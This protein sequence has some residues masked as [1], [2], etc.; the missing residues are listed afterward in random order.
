R[1]PN[2]S[3]VICVPLAAGYT[4]CRG[5]TEILD[6]SADRLDE[7]LYPILV[8]R[9]SCG[10]ILL[11]N[12]TDHSLPQAKLPEIIPLLEARYP[13]I[14]FRQSS[15]DNCLSAMNETE[16]FGMRPL[17]QGELLYAPLLDGSLSTRMMV[18]QENRRLESMLLSAVEPLVANA[19]LS[20]RPDPSAA[21]IDRAWD[22]LLQNHAHDSIRGCSAD[23][24]MQ[25][26]MNRFQRCRQIAEELLS[27]SMMPA[28]W[29][30][31]KTGLSSHLVMSVFNPSVGRRKE[32]IIAE[33]E[34]PDSHEY[35]NFELLLEGNPVRYDILGLTPFCKRFYHPYVNPSLERMNRWKLA[36][37]V[38]LPGMS[39]LNLGVRPLGSSSNAQ[40]MDA[41][42]DIGRIAIRRRDVSESSLSPLPG[43]LEN[44]YIRCT[45]RND[46]S[47][48]VTDKLS[49]TVYERL[50]ML[51]MAD[52][53]GDLYESSELLSGTSLYPSAGKLS[54]VCNT[55]LTA[56]VKVET[57]F[58][59]SRGLLCVEAYF[60]L[61][62]GSHRVEVYV[63]GHNGI[64]N[65]ILKSV[66]CLPFKAEV[67]YAH[68]PFDIVRRLPV[69]RDIERD[70]NRWRDMT[71]RGLPCLYGVF[72]NNN[73][74]GMAIL[75]RG[76]PEYRHEAASADKAELVLL[77]GTE[78]GDSFPCPSEGAQCQGMFETEYAFAATGSGLMEFLHQAHEY[79]SSLLS[80]ITCRSEGLEKYIDIEG[81]GIILESM[82]PFGKDGRV[83]L[84]LCNYLEYDTQVSIRLLITA[85]IFLTRLDGSMLEELVADSKSCFHINASA[86]QILTCVI[87]GKSKQTA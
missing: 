43:V 30:E 68:M 22:L 73:E 76:Q 9:C 60:T 62:K 86:K 42:A 51:V 49:G 72:F 26:V 37:D 83:M 78:F 4:N 69:T 71:P 13:E 75:T 20:G 80:G 15:L 50:N 11:L 85:R 81:E 38:E 59:N 46:A 29:G 28:V 39:C 40:H 65:F 18:K 74:N 23:K 33:L 6:E 21:F 17:W 8:P 61:S 70:G 47:M 7:K 87:A 58:E 67:S 2:G 31:G 12:G 57:V 48:D 16:D 64:K 44:E 66:S 54:C 35:E 34:L 45:V 14:E 36:V 53:A 77:R 25:D 63:K 1:A 24:V 79:N 52:D 27:R 19:V 32:V 84:R 82:R 56:T 3:T 10:H 5:I 41:V 55:S